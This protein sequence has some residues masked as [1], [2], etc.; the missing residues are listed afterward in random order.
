MSGTLPAL[1]LAH[2]Y[3]GE[4]NIY[5]DRGNIAVLQRRL[6]W[7]GLTLEVAEIGIGDAVRP[8]AIASPIPIVVTSSDRPRQ[9]SRWAMTAM[10]P[11]SA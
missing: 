4:M 7:R 6:G 8:G 2:L 10:L 3:P 9:A 1:R 5:A 11:R